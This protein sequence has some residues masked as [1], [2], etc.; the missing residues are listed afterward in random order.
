MGR[1][2]YT[3]NGRKSRFSVSYR[4]SAISQKNQALWLTADSRQLMTDSKNAIRDRCGYTWGPWKLE[5]LS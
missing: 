3:R 2:Y 4:L 5:K 1:R